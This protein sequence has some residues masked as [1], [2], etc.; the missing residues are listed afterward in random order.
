MVPCYALLLILVG[1]FIWGEYNMKVYKTE[2]K[3]M[4]D[5]YLIGLLT[6]GD[7]KTNL[8]RVKE[9]LSRRFKIKGCDELL[10]MWKN[11]KNDT[12]CNLLEDHLAEHYQEYEGD[13]KELPKL[14]KKYF[15]KV[16]SINAIVT[17][18][19]AK[20]E[21]INQQAMYKYVDIMG[22]YL[23]YYDEIMDSFY[24]TEG[25]DLESSISNITSFPKQKNTF[26]TE[27]QKTTA[28]IYKISDLKSRRR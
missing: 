25:S 26:Q 6:A 18:T 1:V 10:M 2:L 20:C 27:N 3:D 5:Y 17:L 19:Y 14:A 23:D 11:S 28:K 15:E 22:E 9:E 7:Y 24:K 16:K 21:R 12:I 8:H 13:Y 4:S